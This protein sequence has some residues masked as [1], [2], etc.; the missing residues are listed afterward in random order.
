MARKRE[1]LKH[2][3][4][5]SQEY[6]NR[7]LAQEGLSLDQGLHPNLIYV[8][9]KTLEILQQDQGRINPKQPERG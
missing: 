5:E 8:D 2:L 4:Y 9:N 3:N 7:L 1:K 6:W